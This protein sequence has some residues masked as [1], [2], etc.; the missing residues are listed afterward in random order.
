MR[1]FVLSLTSARSVP[2]HSPSEIKNLA[3]MTCEWS[4]K[5]FPDKVRTTCL[6]SPE[7]RKQA[8]E[9]DR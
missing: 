6:P 5:S 4:G 9:A 1:H 3:G 8:G 7:V 2:N